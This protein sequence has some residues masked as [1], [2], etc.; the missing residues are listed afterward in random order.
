M[1]PFAAAVERLKTIPGVDQR[2]AEGLVAEIGTDMGRFPTS[3]HLASWAGMCPG[4]DQSAGKHRSGRTT[5]GDRWLRQ[6]LTQAAW[7]ASHTK[8]RTCR[9]STTA[10]RRG[11][12]RSVRSW[13]WAIRC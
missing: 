12:G 8:G 6:T 10:W 13:R 1:P 7:A 2:T 5:K 11:G 3:G 9:R 4:N